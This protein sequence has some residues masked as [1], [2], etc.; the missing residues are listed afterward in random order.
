MD[1]IKSTILTIISALF[2]GI[3]SIHRV[4]RPSPLGYSFNWKPALSSLFLHLYHSWSVN[5]TKSFTGYSI[6]IFEIV[7]LITVCT[8]L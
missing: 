8:E 3:K 1:N 4:G 6:C 2:S 5:L 7:V